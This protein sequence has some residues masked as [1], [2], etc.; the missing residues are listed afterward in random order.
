MRIAY[1]LLFLLAYHT[2][3]SQCSATITGGGAICADGSISL[4]ITFDGDGPWTITYAKDGIA[5]PT[6]ITTNDN[7]Y[8]LVVGEIGTYTIASAESST[9]GTGDILGSA[10]VNDN[11]PLDGGVIL[12]HK[13]D[14][15][16]T[17]L[18]ARAEDGTPPYEYLW[19]NGFTGEEQEVFD[20]E[21]YYLTITDA[22]G[23]T[24]VGSA[25]PYDTICT[26]IQTGE[27]LCEGNEV[28]LTAQCNDPTLPLVSFLWSN[29][30]TTESITV[31]E[32]GLHSVTI[33][34]FFNCEYVWTIAIPTPPD[35]GSIIGSVQNDQNLDC[36]TDSTDIGLK[37]WLVRA[38]GNEEFFGITDS[39]GNY[40]ISV[41]PDDYEV[42][43]IRPNPDYWDVCQSSF[44]TTIEAANDI[45]SVDFLVQDLVDCP[46]MTVDVGTWAFRRCFETVATVEYCN[47][48]TITAEDAYVEITL[49][50]LVTIDSASIPYTGQ[51]VTLTPL[52]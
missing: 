38:T 49:D 11:P 16:P 18:R 41:L 20:F 52:N 31:T 5:D 6:P 25:T 37:N 48:G 7:P 27:M 24:A 21:T 3:S 30:E 10:V 29:G 26:I 1:A 33:S 40:T 9:C 2:A 23:C 14:G 22:A 47:L 28:T 45:D 17:E 13:C 8:L 44:M 4:P 39:S 46:Y 51:L 43:V 32:S 36:L 50:P 15:K 35:C 19:S 34:A 42:E 12:S